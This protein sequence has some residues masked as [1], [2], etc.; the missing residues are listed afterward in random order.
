[1]A[2]AEEH[3][4]HLVIGRVHDKALHLADLAVKSMNMLVTT[5]FGFT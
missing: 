4:R 1:M 5:H 3:V 2:L